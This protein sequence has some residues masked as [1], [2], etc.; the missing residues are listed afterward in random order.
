M[1]RK[2]RIKNLRNLIWVA[3]CVFGGFLLHSASFGVVTSS[4]LAQE[5]R[6]K[7]FGVVLDPWAESQIHFWRRIYSE[8]SSEEQ[9]IHDSMNLSHIYSVTKG[10]AEGQ[11]ARVEIIRKLNGIAARFR[12]T[13]DRDQLTPE[14]LKLF[15]ALDAIEDPRAYRFAANPGRVRIQAGLKDRLEDAFILSR[16]YLKR[17]Q[18]I[19]EEEGVPKELGFL[20]FVESAF[21]HEARSGVGAVGIWQFMPAT[22]QRDLRVTREID[23]RYDPLKS[24]R[25]AARFLKS[26]YQR[27]GSWALA[28]MAYHHGAGLVKNGV[29]KVGSSDPLVLIRTFKDPRFR[30]ASRNYLFEFLAMCDFGLQQPEWLDPRQPEGLP[31][32]ITVSFPKRVR[33]KELLQ[34]YRLNE[35]VTRVLNP[36]FR[37]AIWKSE[38]DIPAHYPI[39]LAGISLEEFRRLEYPR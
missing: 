24:T 2:K 22:A 27:L 13:V 17:M 26:N 21:N 9:V 16:R 29:A 7:K 14:E 4:N 11:R 23:E 33:V 20:P 19:L 39:R 25:A 32:F 15:E 3:A 38:A 34:R 37:Q 30:F 12:K 5:E 36:H 31:S 18:E 35:S 28:V 10:V 6:F 8:F 1:K